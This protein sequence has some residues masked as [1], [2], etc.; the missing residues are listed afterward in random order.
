M[1]FLN[2]IPYTIHVP[3][4]KRK[5]TIKNSRI[6]AV[7]VIVMS[8]AV[9]RDVTGPGRYRRLCNTT[10]IS[11]SNILSRK[12]STIISM[13]LPWKWNDAPWAMAAIK[14]EM[15]LFLIS[16]LLSCSASPRSLTVFVSN[17]SSRKLSV[18]FS[19]S[20]EAFHKSQLRLSM[21]RYRTYRKY[22]IFCTTRTPGTV[23]ASPL[24]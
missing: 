6:S 5:K 13:I 4:K 22:C 3:K 20:I 9:W 11:L 15:L 23:P 12:S 21:H 2:Y 24:D 1:G 8:G 19:A 17:K 7:S 18:K 16:A 14:K 10:I